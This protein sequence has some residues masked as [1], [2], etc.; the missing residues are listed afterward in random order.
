MPSRFRAAYKIGTVIKPRKNKIPPHE[1]AQG[2]VY[3]ISELETNGSYDVEYL[4]EGTFEA[5]FMFHHVS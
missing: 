3:S 5:I 2:R 4:K 1:Q